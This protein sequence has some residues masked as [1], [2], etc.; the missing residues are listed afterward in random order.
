MRLSPLSAPGRAE[1]VAERTVESGSVFGRVGHDLH[2]EETFLVERLADRPDPPVHHVG[3]RDHIGARARLV[4]RLAREDL[5]RLV[6]EDDEPARSGL[7]HKPVM[8]VTGV[9]VEGDVGDEAKLRKLALDRAAGAAD[10]VAFVEGFAPLRVLELRVGIGKEG[11]RR[12]A[13]LDRPLGL[14]HR[15][16]DVQPVD[17]RHGGDRNAA[18]VALDQEQRP[19]EVARRQHMLGDQPARPVRLAIAAWAMGEV[20]AGGRGDAGRL[21]HGLLFGPLIHP[22]RRKATG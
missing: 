12:D 10:E 22:L 20:E 7:A 1:R 15:L 18:L 4:Q 3:G 14:A 5:H 17:A 11:D 21:V 16:I 9:G 13:E 6:V 2:V 19:D 8:A